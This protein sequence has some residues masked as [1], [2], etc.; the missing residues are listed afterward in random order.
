MNGDPFEEIGVPELNG[1]NRH[2][3]YGHDASTARQLTN[4]A[5]YNAEFQQLGHLLDENS[6]LPNGER[7]YILTEAK[8]NDH[9]SSAVA[10]LGEL[11]VKSIIWVSDAEKQ[12]FE[13]AFGR[14]IASVTTAQ[15]PE[16]S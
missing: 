6:T 10:H 13:D 16:A 1:R 11:G 9:I 4:I 14:F 5:R 3:Y 15:Y 7:L 2:V 12:E 8:Y